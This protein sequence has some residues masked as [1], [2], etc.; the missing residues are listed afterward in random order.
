MP[1]S[2]PSADPVP[3]PGR[4]RVLF[5]AVPEEARPFERHWRRNGPGSG[6]RLHTVVTGMGAE[7]AA[8]VAREMVE[9][10][11]PHWVITSGFAGGLDPALGVGEVVFDADHDFPL[12]HALR[13]AEVRMGV[14]V[15][16]DRVAVTV[17]EKRALRVATGADAVEMESSAIRGIC[18]SAGIPSATVR[19]ISDAAGDDLPLD[20]NALMGP[21]HRLRMERLVL[22]V[23]SSPRLIP[24]LL[25][26][27]RQVN[28]AA[29]ELA[30]RLTRVIAE[31]G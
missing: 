11:R 25:R 9:R 27:Q 20:F 2:R 24:R 29:G 8:R 12:T 30:R 28:A 15:Q 16:A 7:N 5:F 14:L 22:R 6:G 23:L 13:R 3:A 10:H 17:A 4:G 19:V 18:R 21:G 1:A 26:F 31:E